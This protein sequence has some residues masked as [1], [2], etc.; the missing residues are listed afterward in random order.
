MKMAG[1]SGIAKCTPLYTG[2]EEKRK[3]VERDLRPK[4]LARYAF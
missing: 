4:Q 1:Q 2:E 3:R